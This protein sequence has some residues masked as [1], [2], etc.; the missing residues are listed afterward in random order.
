MKTDA[1]QQRGHEHRIYADANMYTGI[2]YGVGL[3]LRGQ[4]GLVEGTILAIAIFAMQCAIANL[5]LR[6]FLFG[7]IEWLWRRATYGLPIA[8]LRNVSPNG[9]PASV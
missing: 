9:S 7:P 6:W 4:I 1:G 8:L 2:F 5:W 3:G